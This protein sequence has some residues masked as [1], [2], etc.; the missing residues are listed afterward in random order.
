[1]KRENNKNSVAPFLAAIG[2]PFRG[3]GHQLGN[4]VVRKWGDKIAAVPP[5]FRLL[6]GLMVELGIS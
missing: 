2:G 1:M 3:A 4:L 5:H 6:W